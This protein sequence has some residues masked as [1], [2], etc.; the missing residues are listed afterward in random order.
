[1]LYHFHL[2]APSSLMEK[3]FMDDKE[4]GIFA[5][6]GPSRPNSIGLSVVRLEKVA[7]NLLSI[8]ELDIVDGTPLLDIKPY[9]P[10]FDAARATSIGWMG[11]K[12]K[13][14]PEAKDDG[15]FST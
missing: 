7:G 8:A 2:A 12:M 15:R 5:I 14:L 6:R 13:R 4:R 3:P 11:G 9:V 1:L 10:E